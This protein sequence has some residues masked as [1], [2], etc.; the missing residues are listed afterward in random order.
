MEELINQSVI[1]R[2]PASIKRLD[3]PSQ[4]A[5]ICLRLRKSE[6][7]I[8]RSLN[9]SHSD[10]REK[11]NA[12]RNELIK[13][14]QIDLIEDPEIISIHA[15]TSDDQ[16]MPISSNELDVEN[17]LIIKEFL[18]FMKDAVNQL[19]EH[20]SRLLKLR[21][22]HQMSAKDILGF[23]NKLEFS[24]IPEKDVKELKEQDIFYALNVA[25]KDVLKSLKSRYN[26]KKSLGM[27]NLKYV[28]EEIGA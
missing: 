25:L 7:E 16:D 9:L 1:D 11:I 26:D 3:T 4:R 24:I 20:Q 19:P 17:K 6:N 2:L 23:C 22:K 27:E 14:G 28:F 18:A 15:E 12:V 8:A 5:Y 21:Y 13:A 10:A